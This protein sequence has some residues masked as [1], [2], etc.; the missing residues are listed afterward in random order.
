MSSLK[1][2]FSLASLIL[3]IAFLVIPVMAHDTN[4]DATGI[5]H[6][7]TNLSA[8]QHDAIDHKPRP[9]VTMALMDIKVG[10]KSTIKGDTVQLVNDADAD[11]LALNPA[12]G[13]ANG[14]FQ[15]KVTFSEAV[16]AGVDSTVRDFNSTDLTSDDLMITAAAQSASGRNLFGTTAD[17][18][19]TVSVVRATDPD[20]TLKPN[21]P[22]TNRDPNPSSF[23]LTFT[24]PLALNDADAD[25]LPIDV[26]ITVKKDA[27]FNR[28]GLVDGTS[29][30][31][32]GN[33]ASMRKKVTVIEAVQTNT[34]DIAVPDDAG[35][36]AKFTAT[37]T[38]SE[39]VP[40]LT[41]D[42]LTVTG[43]V[44]G[45]PKKKAD[46]DSKVWT[47]DI[48]PIVGATQ[49]TIDVKDAKAI[50]DV[51]KVPPEDSANPTGLTLAADGYLVIAG[52]NL[53]TATLPNVTPTTVTGF[54]EDLAGFLIAGGTIDV[55]ATGG[56]VII[57][58]LMI[59][60]DSEK[61]NAGT[62]ND[63]QWIE[64]YN[65]HAEETARGIQVTFNSAR[66]APA[67]PTGLQDRLSNVVNP[68][69]IF[70]DQFAGSPDVF[71]GSTHNDTPKDFV[72]IVR[73]YKADKT[74]VEKENGWESA[75]WGKA[76]PLLTFATGRIGTPGK[77]NSVKTFEP[78]KNVT[79]SRE[80][81]INEVANRMN[82]DREWI[83]L[84]GPAGK[85]LKNWKLSIVTA[86]GTETEIF[87]FPDNDNIKISPNGYLLLTDVD[88]KD[89]LRGLAPD[90]KGNV[91]EPVRYKNAVV[92]LK[93][94]PNDGNF[95]LVLRSDKTKTNHEAIQDIAGYD[96][97]LSR[98]NPYTELWPLTGDVTVGDKQ[99]GPKNKLAGGKVYARVRP[100][101]DGY[102][103]NKDKP[104]ETAFG[105]AGFT[106]IG[107]DRNAPVTAENG[108]T[109]GYANNIVK[110]YEQT[111]TGTVATP[112][113]ISEIMYATGS[114][115][116]LPQWIELYNTSQT[117]AINLAGWRV[118][119]MNHDKDLD[120]KNYRGKSLS[121]NY[122]L[123]GIIPPNQTFLLV[124]Y[125]GNNRTQL[126]ERRIQRLNTKRG[127]LI[128]SQHAFE[129]VLYAKAKDNKDE[130]RKVADIAGNLGTVTDE[131]NPQVRGNPRSYVEP[132]WELPMGTNED[133]Q[134]VSIVRGWKNGV[135]D[136]STGVV[137]RS[138]DRADL[139]PGD[140]KS[141]WT[142]YSMNQIVRMRNDTSYG[143]NTDMGSPGQTVGGVL[144]VSLSKFRP[145]RL[146]TGE[147]V[148]RWITESEL[149]NA[150][151]NILRSEKRD[152]QFTK[153][154]TSLIAGQG[155]TSERTTYSLVDTSAKPNVVYY[156]QIQDVSLDGEVQ[157]L[158]QS[159]LKGDVSPAGKLTT[160]WAEIKALQ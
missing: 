152:G 117:E 105:V 136:T 50:G 120:D 146:D 56:D 80:V 138:T 160:Q 74:T 150:G 30:F 124:A 102:A 49:V 7:S 139:I 73:V 48:T 45:T 88:P 101:L 27:V 96:T 116:N 10:G 43:G 126:P 34:V 133:G 84:K 107:Y 97:G 51:I 16:Y 99:L 41:A 57:N 28:T 148:I 58:E 89:D 4:G 109:P 17:T 68:G 62:Q 77:R 40:A 13:T 100:D 81:T 94:L 144:P 83:E 78:V 1:M 143:H 131:N 121:A 123:S 21:D 19:I 135:K 108:G 113:I 114:R 115:A 52:S 39:D 37:L 20:N 55:V 156:Y 122:D 86:I 47:V 18:T 44:A 67:E 12:D 127:E 63:G 91:P 9:T 69:W 23:I 154:N 92:E 26:W 155:T 46:D 14:E 11:T 90:L 149:N 36:T 70:A 61:I 54:P 3:L 140:V 42:D 157:T 112:V 98:A 72:S 129:I 103:Q 111:G 2:T 71:N 147:I 141:A 110:G 119:I 125:S 32:D 145:E 104:D 25:E 53:N 60:R 5:Q 24:V 15:V 153:I 93:E 75:A 142:L 6:G 65:K 76:D 106:G 59:A 64:L 66:P 118:T 29:V 130:N 8:A 79:P 85:S 132:A 22:D 151:F 159:R 134:R 95:L 137:T 35:L 82:G 158:R 31:G 33:A 128:L 38:F 87:T